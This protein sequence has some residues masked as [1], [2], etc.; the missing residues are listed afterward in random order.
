MVDDKPAGVPAPPTGGGGGGEGGGG[1]GA[2]APP[3]AGTRSESF[4]RPTDVAFDKSGNVYIA[5]GMGTNNRIAVFNSDGNWVRGWGQTGSG[6]GQFRTIRGI[7]IDAGRQ[8]VRGGC[9]Q[10]P[11]PGLRQP[12]HLQVADHRDRIAAGDLHHGRL[13]TVSLQLELERSREHGQRRDL[14]DLELDG[15]VAGKFGKAGKL[16]G[17]FGMANSLDCRTENT[18]WVGEVWNWRAQ[19]VTL[20]R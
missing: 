7:V 11:H 19:K 10:Q 14:Q 3:G 15:Q 1:A 17:E 20:K 4:N 9:G 5:D 12:R 13:A 6:Q 2:K 16:R 18:L 8:R